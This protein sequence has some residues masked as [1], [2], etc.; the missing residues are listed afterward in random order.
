M[1]NWIDQGETYVDDTPSVAENAAPTQAEIDQFYHDL[2]QGQGGHISKADVAKLQKQILD[3]GTT[4]Q[5]KGQGFGSAEANALDMAKS[6]VASGVTDIHQIAQGTA[7]TKQPVTARDVYNGQPVEYLNG[8]PVLP[9]Y[10]YNGETGMNQV[11]GYTPVPKDK[12]TKTYYAQTVDGETPLTAEEVKTLDLSG[13]YPVAKIASG[14][15]IINKDT[16]E[17]ILSNYNERTTGNAFGGTYAGEGNTAYRVQFDPQGN[18][19]FYTTGASSNTLANILQDSPILNTVANI[20]AS[21]FGGP[22]GAAALQLAQGKSVEDIAKAAALSYA[23]GQVG[24]GVSSGLTDTLGATGANI[25]GNVAKS[26]VTGQDPVQALISGGL[27]AGTNAVLGEIPGFEG[28][29]PKTQAAISKVVSSTLQTGN[30]N[31]NQLI[32]AAIAAGTS[33]AANATNVPTE[34]QVNA[35]NQTL[36]DALAPYEAAP[37]VPA[38]Q[39]YT[40]T[41]D[42]GVPADYSLFSGSTAAPTL[43]EMGGA[44][45]IQAPAVNEKQNVGYEPIDYGLNTSVPFEGLQM[46][47]APNIDSMGGGQGLTVPVQGGTLTESGFIPDTYIP[48]LGDPNS[49]INQPTGGTSAAQAAS[50]AAAS[51]AAADA[52]AKAASDK[53]AADAAA[54]AKAA[55]DAAAKAKADAAVKAYSDAIAQQQSQTNALLNMMDSNNGVANIKS[56]KDLYGHELFGPEPASSA[57]DQTSNLFGFG[58]EQQFS[59]GGDVNA[60]L[61]LLRS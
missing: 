45:G 19:I 12:I 51:K 26:T 1:A 61:Q 35:D 3:Q 29:D 16:G 41:T 14:A 36:I 48:T 28:L 40:P 34:A 24:Q 59:G 8:Q 54:R 53:A 56:Y 37:E 31:P 55:A 2:Y 21:Y 13:A 32:N 23:A 4:S 57:Q 42:Y 60:L 38:E 22:L 10:E 49:F 52:A 25:A 30:L 33:E 27:N 50:Q 7:Y 47:T 44:Q 39:P 5:W 58:A 17:R 43:E 18:P 15:G 46:P 6:L 20:G 11:S 9:Q